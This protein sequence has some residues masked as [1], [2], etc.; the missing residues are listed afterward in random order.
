MR[1]ADLSGV[2]KGIKESLGFLCIPVMVC[3][4]VTVA[5]TFIRPMFVSGKSMEGTYHEGQ[6]LL[7]THMLMGEIERGDIVIAKPENYGKMLIKRVI[8]TE[9][10]TFEI[11][12][13]KVYING[14]EISENYIPE[15]MQTMDFPPV[16]LQKGEY[17]L[18]GDNRN[19]SYDSR[20]LGVITKE[21]IVYKVL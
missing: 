2:K 4:L 9:G 20:E 1:H 11:R 18:M 12:S 5:L 6:I 16:T 10:D 19:H 7:A 14:K 17:F 13:G 3:I 15:P 21:E 8:A